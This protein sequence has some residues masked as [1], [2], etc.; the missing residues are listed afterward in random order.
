[1]KKKLFIFL[2]AISFLFFS[3]PL[4]AQSRVVDNAGLLSGSEIAELERLTA[5]IASTYNFDI[6]IVTEK[7]I[8]G[9]SPM[10]YADDFFDYN[11][12][13]LG[14][15]RDGC[16]FLQ[17]T[18]TRDYWFSTSGRGINILNSTA[19]ER[20]EQNV[21]K[22]LKNDEPAQAYLSFINDWEKFLVLDA[23]GKSYNFIHVHVPVI[24]RVA[25]IVSLI[26]GFFSVMA[27]KAKMNNVH[28]K[29]EANNFIIPG[30]LAFTQ[31]N[32]IFLYSTVTKSERAESSSSSGGGS[33]ISSSGRSHGGGGGKY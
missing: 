12:Y 5:E 16:L 27:M 6:V 18:E 7:N 23:K 8:S 29:M 24:Y 21:V 3:F 11:G 9:A 33:H 2:P 32:D 17:V 31:K 22:F 10:D 14:Q 26:I 13:G 28:P 4:F 20:L 19:Y 25:W 30:S 1:M 15:D